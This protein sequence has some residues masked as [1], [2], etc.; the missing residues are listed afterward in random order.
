MPILEDEQCVG[1]NGV[2]GE[3]LMCGASAFMSAAKKLPGKRTSPF[4]M[5]S[6]GEGESALTFDL[7]CGEFDLWGEEDRAGREGCV[8]TGE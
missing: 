2:P 1:G 6:L 7:L 8:T 5:P 4:L 3:D